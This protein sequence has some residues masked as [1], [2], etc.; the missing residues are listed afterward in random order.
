MR[1][2]LPKQAQLASS[3]PRFSHNRIGVVEV[4]WLGSKLRGATVVG[5][6]DSFPVGFVEIL[7]GLR[8]SALG[9]LASSSTPV[10]ISF[11]PPERPPANGLPHFATQRREVPERLRGGTPR[12]CCHAMRS[13]PRCRRPHLRAPIAGLRLP[14]SRLGAAVGGTRSVRPLLRGG[15]LRG[16]V[17]G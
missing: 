3:I 9:E 15:A 14:A 4:T 11:A 6:T 1:R 10:G 7:Q 12:R 8:N 16:D 5:P 13:D 17:A 2:D